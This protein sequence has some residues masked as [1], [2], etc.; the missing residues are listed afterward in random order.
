M[1]ESKTTE[2]DAILHDE[3]SGTA[4]PIGVVTLDAAMRMQV[5][6]AH[7]DHAEFLNDL[8]EDANGLDVLHIDVAPPPGAKQ[9]ARYSRTV[10][11]DSPEFR[12]ALIERLMKYDDVE[13]K[14]R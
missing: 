12:E 4:T 11:R 1:A 5:Q 2:F 13:L 9:G 7:P 10:K 14:Q 8:A 3:D 6:S